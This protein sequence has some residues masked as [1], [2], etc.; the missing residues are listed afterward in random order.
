MSVGKSGE[1]DDSLARSVENGYRGGSVRLKHGDLR[2]RNGGRIWI[3]DSD[4][5]VGREQCCR[6]K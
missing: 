1:Q 5:Q 6:K 4:F 2:A 3:G